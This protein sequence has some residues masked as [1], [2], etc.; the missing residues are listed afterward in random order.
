MTPETTVFLLTL[1]LA[2]IHLG[3]GAMV[4]LSEVGPRV[5]LGPRDDLPPRKNRFGLRGERANQN[6]KET[7][8]WALGLL[9]LVQVTGQANAA[10][11]MGAWIYVVS[12]AVY[13]PLYVF[14]VPLL[15][16]VAFMGSLVGMGMIAVQIL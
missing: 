15:R 10:S 2:F 7:L 4:R 16:T 14:G 11:A 8:P 1:V 3:V 6:F 9:I 12:R 13:L 5:L